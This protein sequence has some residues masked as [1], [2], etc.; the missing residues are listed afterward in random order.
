ML[1]DSPPRIYIID[2][3]PGSGKDTLVRTLLHVLHSE[4]RPVYYYPEEC[5]AFSY[6][7]VFWPGITNVRLTI[8]E[9]ALDFI[10]EESLRSP[11]VVFVFNRFHL[12]TA[13]A[14][15]TSIGQDREATARYDRL[16]ERLHSLRVLVLLLTLDESRMTRLT[17]Q[18]RLG[19]DWVWQD[20]LA[21]VTADTPHNSLME[22]YIYQQERFLQLAEK[23][24][25]PYRAGS[26]PE[27]VRLEQKEL[28]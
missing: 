19:H 26:L 5:M 27:L 6:G 13:V 11:D 24:A 25:L 17:H 22:L 28:H 3:I 16:V 23:Q 4:S 15:H 2:G 18:E 21:R 9:A 7:Q 14:T 10:Q 8:M 20:F 1:Q 12:S